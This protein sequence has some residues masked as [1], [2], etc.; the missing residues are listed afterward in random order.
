MNALEGF[1]AHLLAPLALPFW[2][3]IIKSTVALALAALVCQLLHRQS[4]ALRHRVWVLGLVAS[5]VVPAGSL[6]LPQ[7]MLPVLPEMMDPSRFAPTRDSS[8]PSPANAAFAAAHSPAAEPTTRS[9]TPRPERDAQAFATLPAAAPRAVPAPA[10]T[11]PALAASRRIEHV[12]AACWL[13]GTLIGSTVLVMSLAR[14]S[15]RLQRLRRIEDEEWANS[16]TAAACEMGLDRP[17]VAVESDESCIPA[18]VGVLSPRLVIPP[19]WRTWSRPQRHCILL[20][21]LAHV[22]RRDVL[23]QLLGRLALLC[24]WFNPLVW[25]AVRRLRGERELASDDCVLLAGQAASDYAEQ[26]LRTLRCYRDV[27]PEMG[28]AMAHSPRL[29]HRVLAILDPR[30]RR[31]P[32]SSRFAVLMTCLVGGIGA[33]LCGVTLTSPVAVANPQA[34]SK[35][36]RPAESAALVW[37]E[38]YAVEYPGTLPVSVTFSADGKVLLTGDTAGEAMA[39]IFVDGEPRWRWKSK[40]DGSHAA[41]AF[42]ADQQQIYATTQHG[43]RVLDAAGGKEQARVEERDSRPIAVGVFPDKRI[44]DNVT[45]RQIVFGTPRG[46]FVESWIDGKLADTTSTLETSTVARDKQPDDEAAV[47][48]AVDPFG[49]SAIMTGP[50]DATGAFGGVKGK[51]VVWA[52]VC[53]DYDEGSPG[54]RVMAGHAATVV[55][56]AWAK[57]GGTAVTGDAAGRVIVWDAKAMKEVGRLELGGRVAAL[58][59]SGDGTRT[60]AYVLGKQGDVYVW[61]T[62]RPV[63][64]MK[65]IHVELGDFRG[66]QVHASLAFSPDGRQLAGCAGNKEWL[67]R[68]GELIGKVRVWELSAEPRAQLPPKQSYIMP[69]PRGSSGNFVIL[70]NHTMLTPAAKIGAVDF[71]SVADGAILSRI[72]L[73]DF[74]IGGMKLSADRRWLALEQLAPSDN[75]STGTPATTFEIGVYEVLLRHQAAIPACSRLL[76]IAAGGKVVAVVREKQ[77]ELWDTAAAQR[78]KA[79][80]FQYMRIDAASFS[81]DGKLLAITSQNELVLW[82]W[83]ENSHERIDRGRSVG[84]LAFSPDGR[85]L[86]EGPAPGENIQVRDLETRR[87]VQTLAYG[88]KRSMHVPSMAYAQS[89]RVLIACD[90]SVYAKDIAVPHR[91]HLWDLADGS[92]AH[93]LAVPEGLP[94]TFDVS[95]NGR[96]LVAMLEDSEGMK[97]SGWRLDGQDSAREAGTA[98]P[99]AV[100][101]R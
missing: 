67:T 6:L 68:G 2:G 13:L 26:L 98:P 42:S 48:L 53:G 38:N 4:A 7:L 45:R 20:H 70:D 49:R 55:S 93:Q 101:P 96:F 9:I 10:D 39:L 99:A 11:S 76:D 97:L 15:V 40:V 81:P 65:P 23:A 25:H 34:D 92:L 87:V 62:A 21:E 47:P 58:A 95:P 75:L 43:V 56:A 22:K 69:L 1:P 44:G 85:F 78:L 19:D 82:R 94:Q 88:T 41:V 37:K 80:P 54:N 18:A 90:K 86:A 63:D 73:G 27:R 100:T 51:N 32:V 29:D 16:M 36:A 59:I 31:E 3:I 30:R 50:V 57:Q 83:E 24:Y 79:A 5:L 8:S 52:Y 84:S 35:T 28:V 60:A 77:V 46:Y 71:R 14:Q 64:A 66:P 89:G 74:V 33:V 72:V 17:V 12:L 61:E 91:I